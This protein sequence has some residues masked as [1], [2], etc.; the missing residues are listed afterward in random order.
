[1]KANREF[2]RDLVSSVVGFSAYSMYLLH[3]PELAVLILT[4]IRVLIPFAV[5][6]YIMDESEEVQKAYAE[7]GL[8]DRRLLTLCMIVEIV[9]LIH[10]IHWTGKGIIWLVRY[11][12]ED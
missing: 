5:F 4:A 1:M 12:I 8:L 11:Y 6:L 10:I 2:R 3:V 7:Y 9:I